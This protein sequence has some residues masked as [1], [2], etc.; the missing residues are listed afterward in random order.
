LQAAYLPSPY[1]PE[2]AE[3]ALR[4]EKQPITLET[5]PEDLWKM[6]NSWWLKIKI[7]RDLREQEN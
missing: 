7:L 4:G 5:M 2:L 1:A 6:F 3:Y